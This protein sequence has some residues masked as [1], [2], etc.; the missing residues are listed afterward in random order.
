MIKGK[1]QAC[2]NIFENLGG[3]GQI[4]TKS[5][6]KQGK[7]INNIEFVQLVQKKKKRVCLS[8]YQCSRKKKATYY[9]PGKVQVGVH[10][11]YKLLMLA[12][13]S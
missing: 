5:F 2:S 4:P 8:D 12:L 3:G 9:P 13:I 7:N 1:N 11:A 6:D 10:Q